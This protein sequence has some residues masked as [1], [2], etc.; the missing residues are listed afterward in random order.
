MA[1][2]KIDARVN[3]EG[4]RAVCFTVRA[5][6]AGFGSMKCTIDYHCETEEMATA[7]MEAGVDAE[8]LL[9][10]MEIDPTNVADVAVYVDAC[11][12]ALLGVMEAVQKQLQAG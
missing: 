6:A 12:K 8:K 4:K 9:D 1:K 3:R 2:D 5:K 7:I 11:G 10:N